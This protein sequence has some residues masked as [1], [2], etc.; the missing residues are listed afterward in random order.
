MDLINILKQEHRELLEQIK[1]IK[2]EG[3]NSNQAKENICEF[4]NLLVK[5][6]RRE[7]H[8]LY[9]FLNEVAKTNV[10]IE[11]MLRAYA[12]EINKIEEESLI[13]FNKFENNKFTPEELKKNFDKMVAKLEIRIVS[14]EK[15]LFPK[16]SNSKSKNK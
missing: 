12:N 16:Y 2:R 14:E 3:I 5:H 10:N 9:P 11:I 4:K 13:F 1:K 7:D 15:K 6:L 8:D